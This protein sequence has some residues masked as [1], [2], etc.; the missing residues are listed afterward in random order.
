M[1]VLLKWYSR[2]WM[3]NAV[4]VVEQLDLR[5]QRGL[6]ELLGVSQEVLT[7][8]AQGPSGPQGPQ[9]LTGPQGSSIINTKLQVVLALTCSTRTIGH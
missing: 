7:L 4:T 3:E 2:L 6:R 9:G 1:V 5:V 8:L